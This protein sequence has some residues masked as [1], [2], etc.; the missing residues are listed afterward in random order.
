MGGERL[1]LRRWLGKGWVEGR[2]VGLRIGWRRVGLRLMMKYWSLIHGRF[3]VVET[4]LD[5][6]YISWWETRQP[7]FMRVRNAGW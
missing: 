4:F 5:G 1:G 6:W 7:G 3:M 2:R